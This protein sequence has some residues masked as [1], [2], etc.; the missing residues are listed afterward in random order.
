MKILTL[1][2]KIQYTYKLLKNKIISLDQAIYI[3]HYVAGNYFKNFTMELY[4]LGMCTH[5]IKLFPYYT[6]LKTAL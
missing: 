6:T 5:F 2:I 3:F 1:S 4:V